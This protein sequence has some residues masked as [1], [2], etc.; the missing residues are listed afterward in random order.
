MKNENDPVNHPDHYTF[1]KAIYEPY[2]ATKNLPHPMASAVEYILRAPY[3]GSEMTDLRKADWWLTCF[4]DNRNLLDGVRDAFMDAYKAAPL[5]SMCSNVALLSVWWK[6]IVSG[7]A[8]DSVI[9]DATV[10]LRDGVRDRI[11]H[12]EALDD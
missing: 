8:T 5:A 12:T 7:G 9:Y 11:S 1:Y 10:D 2:D 6:D 3:K 4:L